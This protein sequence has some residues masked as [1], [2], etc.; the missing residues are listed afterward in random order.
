MSEEKI[1]NVHQKLA[2]ARVLL[3]EKNLKK[4]GHNKYAGFDY[5]ELR[6]FLPTVNEINKKLGILSTIKHN[7]GE[8][9]LRITNNENPSEHIDFTCEDFTFDQKGYNGAQ[10][11]GSKHTYKKRYLYMDAYEIA[12]NDVIDATIGK[13][14]KEPAKKSKPKPKAKA[15][16]PTKKK[17]EKEVKEKKIRALPTEEKVKAAIEYAESMYNTK[18]NGESET[19]NGKTVK[20]AVEADNAFISQVIA[21]LEK[22]SK[23]VKKSLGE[24]AVKAIVELNTMYEDASGKRLTLHEI[25]Q[26]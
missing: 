20:E 19:L 21:K 3:Q 25:C 6:D 18:I 1:K 5:F 12:E 15:S 11:T 8:S 14:E 17:E 2:E 4:T 16:E 23:G 26:Q 24:D 10:V 22:Q 13:E 7:E 9:V